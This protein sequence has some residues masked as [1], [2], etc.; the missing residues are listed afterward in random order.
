MSASEHLGPQWQHYDALPHEAK[1][2]V[3]HWTDAAT[4][5]DLE[6]GARTTKWAVEH[7]PTEVVKRRVME[8][9]EL[10]QS[11]PDFDSYHRW[12]VAGGDVPDHGS[13]RWPVIAAS[14]EEREEEGTYLSDGHHRLHSYV[15][16]G[17][18]TIP[19]LR[20]RD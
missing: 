14:N 20:A 4:P 5:E 15:R 11:H 17:D 19:V 13:S 2:A 9:H 12:Y 3:R 1:Q 16:A 10:S 8:S 6:E 18:K 7:V